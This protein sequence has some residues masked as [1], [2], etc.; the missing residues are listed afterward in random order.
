M[1]NN[2]SEISYYERLEITN[3]ILNLLISMNKFDKVEKSMPEMI[4]CHFKNSK[5]IP[6]CK[7]DKEFP[8]LTGTF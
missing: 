1:Q 5:I 4:T 3:I 6:K 7:N 8:I 2:N